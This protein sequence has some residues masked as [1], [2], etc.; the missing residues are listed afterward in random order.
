[1]INIKSLTKSELTKYLSNRNEPKYRANQIFRWLHRDKIDDFSK[2]TN[3]NKNLICDLK[4]NFT[5]D[6]ITI[7]KKIESVDGSIKYLIKLYDDNIIESVLLKAKYGFT[8]CMSSQVGCNMGCKF[9]AST[10]NGLIRN[11]DVCE[12]LSQFYIIKK[13]TELNISNIVIMGSGEP[14]NNFENFI[15]F[16]D[17]INDV[18]GENLSHRNITISTCGIVDKIYKLADM[19]LSITLALSLH[20][21]S[22]MI[23]NSIMPISK[24]YKLNEVLGAMEYYYKKTKR[25]ITFEY[26]LIKNIN[27]S[28]NCAKDLTKLL[29]SEMKNN[30]VDFNVNLIPINTIDNGIFLPPDKKQIMVFKKVLEDSKINVTVRRSQGKD[31]SGSCG[32]LVNRF[33]NKLEN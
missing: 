26:S 28:V 19:K 33:I 22:D 2:M 8:V 31:I 20:A 18:D 3:I 21:S 32:Q 12:L 13:D 25:R 7:Y 29:I 10:K 15:K 17:I 1:M 14:L 9:C 5:L 30:G 23:R 11:L 4:E 27:D 16:L 6:K 24:K